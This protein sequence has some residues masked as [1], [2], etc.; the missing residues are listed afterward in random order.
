MSEMTPE[1]CPICA[2]AEEPC[3]ACRKRI[4]QSWH[5]AG[6]WWIRFEECDETCPSHQAVLAAGERQYPAD[7]GCTRH[8]GEPWPCPKCAAL[9]AKEKP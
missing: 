2:D 4:H 3:E 7:A 8:V 1:E 9:V 5:A 6:M